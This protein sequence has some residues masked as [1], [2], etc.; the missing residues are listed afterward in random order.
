MD[1]RAANAPKRKPSRSDEP[2]KIAEGKSGAGDRRRGID[3]VIAL[4]DALLQQHRPTR[5]GEIARLIGAPRST[6]YEIVSRLVEADILKAYGTDGH[7]YFGRAAHLFG[8]AYADANPL[9]RRVEDVLER[10]AAETQA[11]TQFCGL[12]G[13]KYVVIDSRDGG[14]L[15]RIT[16]DVGIEV[17]IPWTASGR[18]LLDHMSPEEIRAFVPPEDFRLPDGRMLPVEEFLADVARARADGCCMT[19]GLADRF[20]CCLAAP[21]RDDTGAASNTLCFVIPADTPEPRRSELLARLI[22]EAE[23]LTR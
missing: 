16:T 19:V 2:K 4:L 15:F 8:R 7:V 10:L 17:P 11:T 20:A 23:L 3:R 6:A 22:A 14:G 18:L 12:K 21:L 13:N 5:I 1:Q 9:V